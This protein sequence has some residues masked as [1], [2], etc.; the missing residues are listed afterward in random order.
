[1]IGLDGT[2]YAVKIAR[3]VLTGEKLEITSNAYLSELFDIEDEAVIKLEAAKAAAV[4]S[5]KNK[6]K[7]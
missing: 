6:S 2:P 1:M 4:K 5:E 7:N 3:T